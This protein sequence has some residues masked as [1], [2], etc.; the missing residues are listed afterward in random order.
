MYRGY[1]YVMPQFPNTDA[2]KIKPTKSENSSQ[3]TA[4]L[5]EF[6]APLMFWRQASGNET[7]LNKE[8]STPLNCARPQS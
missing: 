8:L 4:G 5:L 1:G 2:K 7:T 3:N 6:F